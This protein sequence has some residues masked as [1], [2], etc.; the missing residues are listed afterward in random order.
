MY[1]KLS[2]IRCY[3]IAEIGGNFTTYQQAKDLIDAAAYAGVDAVKLQTF[4]AETISSKGAMFDM[5]STGVISQF[6]YFKKYE[7]G[8]ELHKK[9]FDY[10][11]S[12]ELDWFSTPSHP[13]DVEMLHSL[14][15]CCYKTGAD[16]ATNLPFLKYIAQKGLPIILSS[17]M[18]TLKE[19]EEAV[20]TIEEEGNNRIVILHTVSGYPTHPENVN[21][22]N[23]ITLKERFSHYHV[24]FSDHTLGTTAAI[25]AATMG[26]T[27]VE[28][29]FTLD[30][31]AEG[32][33]HMLSST[34]EEM[35]HIVDTIR[36]IE[37]MRG[38]YIKM[39]FGPEVE[40]RKNNRKS[41]VSIKSIK[42]GEIL[43]EGNVYIKRPGTGISPRHFETILG[44]VARYDIEEEKVLDWQDFI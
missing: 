31:N 16:D 25:A 1:D 38:S 19:V 37:L 36:K 24:G 9:I 41:I 8:K 10:A 34:P 6:D 21:L 20:S 42:K 2:D 27:V 33:D 35:K 23:I 40:N 32:P 15:V 30:K 11:E 14:G 5:E 7:I 28:R 29:H 22:N 13:E 26:T 12:K 18:C 3:I 39:P 44:K 43:A 4:R 17:G